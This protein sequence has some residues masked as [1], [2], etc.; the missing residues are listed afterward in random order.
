M[1]ADFDIVVA[2]GGIAGL[3]AGLHA[4]RLGASTLVLTG[5]VPGGHLLSVGRVDA[6]PGFPEGVEGYRLCPDIQ[7]EA[8]ESGAAIEAASMTGFEPDEGWIAVETGEGVR[9]ARALIVATGTVFET[10]DV[11]GAESLAG[12]GVSHCASCDAPLLR[13]KKVAVVGGGDS[14]LQEALTLAEF[15]ERVTIVHRGAALGG[16]AAYRDRVAAAANIDARL[17]AVVT[18]IH[19]DDGVTGVSLGDGDL[20]VSGVFVYIGL[21][22]NT[23][24]LGGR[25]ALDRRGAIVCRDGLATGLPGVFAAGTVRAA[26]FGRAAAAAGEGASAALSAWRYLGG[27]NREGPR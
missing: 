19:G 11:P 23:G 8:A 6:Y 21:R 24:V 13:G 25:I 22:P 7:L 27:A 14:A 1:S 5:D 3:T 10:L 16:Q 4:A 2:G 15:A 9:N 26:A 12:R 17:G 20:E 18:A